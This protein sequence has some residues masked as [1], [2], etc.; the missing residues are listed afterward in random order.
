MD[1]GLRGR[2]AVVGGGS[3]GLGAAS[4]HA[5]A[6]EGCNLL[7]WSR[8]RER[9]EAVA[10]DLRARH[11]TE[12]SV[13][14]A[15]ASSPDAA[16]LVAEAAGRAFPNG[17]D[18]LVSNAGGPPTADPTQ[19][20]DDAWRTALQ[21]LALTP[22]A[23]ANAL[24]PGMRSRGWGRVV[25]V[26]SSGVRQPIPELVYSNGGRSAL[27]AWLKTTS[28]AVAAD[29]VTINGVMPGRIQ[30]PRVQS[31]DE[32]AAATQGRSLEEVRQGQM[33]TIPARRY[34]RPEEL[35]AL[36]AFL[37]SEPAAYV[38]GQLIAVDGGLISGY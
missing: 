34:G 21:L 20:S 15:D 18:I 32:S 38:N 24:L 19:T 27:A 8:N 10:A 12:V 36:V 14:A 22:I 30:T 33:R 16:Q 17:V 25:A 23:L 11:A 13:V 2:S 37:A 1:L 35:G 6:A 9:L 5:L 4:A 26:L 31:L 29:G 7:L 3:S 28:L